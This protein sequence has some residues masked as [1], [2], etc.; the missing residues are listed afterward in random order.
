M[1]EATDLDIFV[2][3][4]SRPLLLKETLRSILSQS[5]KGFSITVL[6]NSFD[7]E[8]QKIMP[9]FEQKGVKYIRTSPSNT[10]MVNFRAAQNFASKKYTITFHDDDLLHP[11]YLQ[12]VLEVINKFDN[13]NIVTGKCTGFHTG[14]NASFPS[15]LNR[16][17]IVLNG[18]FDFAAYL[19][20][21]GKGGANTPATVYRTDYFKSASSLEQ[22]HK[23]ADWP[24]AIEGVGNGKAVVIDDNY[25]VLTRIHCGQDT[26]NSGDNGTDIEHLFAW[27]AYFADYLKPNDPSSLYYKAYRVYSYNML[28]GLYYYL[29]PSQK[30][31]YSWERV[32]SEAEKRGLIDALAIQKGNYRKNLFKRILTLPYR[33]F[34]KWDIRPMIKKF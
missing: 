10:M 11:K 21:Y 34:N 28:K 33:N 16:R 5:V 25:C 6:D 29:K 32:L 7:D 30:D 14:Q 17:A 9:Y 13:V 27:M 22:F 4:N 2:P 8:T 20:A 26:N 12:R 18:K 31:K 15:D 1:V 24:F 19:Y 3:T 23:N